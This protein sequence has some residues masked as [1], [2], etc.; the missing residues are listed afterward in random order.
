MYVYINTSNYSVIQLLQSNIMKH[1]EIEQY[2]II[3]RW[4]N[5]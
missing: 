1:E 5:N 3:M 4:D 2:V